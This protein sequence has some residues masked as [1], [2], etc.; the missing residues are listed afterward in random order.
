M[1]IAITP[2]ASTT[3]L[4]A[5]LDPGAALQ[6]IITSVNEW[7]QAVASEQTK[8]SAIAV[9]ERRWLAAIDADR[10]A[11]LTYL[12]RTFDERAENFRQLF[13]RLDQ[14]LT[15][16]D[17]QVSEILGAITTL[18]MKCPFQDLKDVTMVTAH[19]DD[20]DYEW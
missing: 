1:T 4:P 12:D 11:L 14:A 19:L 9:E 20:P 7:Q 3:N 13:T 15:T 18:A 10:T 6:M 5:A 8:R 16:G 2:T 17:S